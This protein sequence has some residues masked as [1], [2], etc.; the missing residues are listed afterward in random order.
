MISAL[1]L[2]KHR[3]GPR[4]RHEQHRHPHRRPARL[5]QRTRPR[6]GADRH[7]AAGPARL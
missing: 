2:G 4:K 7:R 1:F 5:D 3:L 6:G